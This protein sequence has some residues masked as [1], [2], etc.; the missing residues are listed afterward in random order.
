MNY[1]TIYEN[2]DYI[3]INKPAGLLTHGADHIKEITLA[4]QLLK[5]YPELIKIGED[6]I[7][8]GIVHRLDRQVSGLLVVAK[9]QKMFEHLKSQFKNRKIIKIYNALVY[10]KIEKD[11]DEINFPIKRSSKG[12]KMAALP[13]TT[14]GELTIEGRRAIT[15]FEIIK[16]FINYTLLKVRIKTGRTHQIRVHMTAYGH[17]IVGDDLYSTK[18]TRE[19][20][21]RL[22][23]QEKIDLNIIYLTAVKLSFTDLDNE[24]KT[25]EIKLPNKFNNLLKIVK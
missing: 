5:K 24:Q 14:K 17:P 9:T 20:N 12:N 3:V 19:K 18:K 6:P 23:K 11:E 1:K 4:D 7:R 16:K 25:F 8:P 13:A 2:K 22:R 15:N 10:G 21:A